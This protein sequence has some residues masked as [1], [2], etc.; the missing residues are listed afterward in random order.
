M[1]V[2]LCGICPH[3]PIMVPE[4]GLGRDHEVVR[5]QEA[6]LELGRQV[7][8]SGAET[9]VIITPHGTVFAD[10]VAVSTFPRLTG[11][12]GQFNA[13]GVRFDLPND[14]EMARAIKSEA[15]SRDITVV[16]ID[17]EMVARHELDCSLD[18]GVT[19]P[20]Y[21][22]VKAGVN[23]PLVHVSMS[24][25]P[26]PKLY[27]FG[28]AVRSA[29]EKLG[30]KVA[31][32]ASG[33]LSHRLTPDAPAGYDPAGADFDRRIVELVSTMNVEGFQELDPALVER[34][35]EC[36]M[37]S[38]VMMLGTLDGMAVDSKVLSYE[39]PFGVGYMV[40]VLKPLGRDDDRCLEDK[41]HNRGKEKTTQKRA[42]ESYPVRLA[43]RVLERYFSGQRQLLEGEEEV[44][45]EFAARRAGVFVSLKKHGQ[46]RGCIGTIEPV[47]D[48]I[49]EEIAENAVSAAVRDPRFHPVQPGEL[50][51]LDISVDI[52]TAPEPVK[53][54]D[55]LDPKKYGVIVSSGGRR[56][57]LL[58]DLEGI[59]SAGEQVAIARQKAGIGPGEPVK[60]ERFRVIRYH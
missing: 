35:G 10:A 48:S 27:S 51:E 37:R 5:T 49:V 53:S 24:M 6:M 7:K 20:L 2:V 47:R 55:E 32:L 11:D 42:G 29:A 28:I 39:G 12:L 59:D 41:L 3:P 46:L 16:G 36:G 1:A 34:A 22:I 54:L 58:P 60:L 21:F 40:A 18:H 31:V 15:G 43:R 17:N 25:L 23:I 45:E 38:I 57:L 13:R 44:P 50:A 33:D 56:G 26:M 9:L 19:V 4:V 52:L 30:R 8:E 14:L